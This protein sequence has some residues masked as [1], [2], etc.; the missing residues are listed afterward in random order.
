[1]ISLLID[2]MGSPSVPMYSIHRRILGDRS[3]SRA[4]L[5]QGKEKCQSRV[6]NL[7]KFRKL[8]LDFDISGPLSDQYHDN[9]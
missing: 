4:G 6:Y 8:L 3:I 5:G 7:P 1:M 2:W 9:N